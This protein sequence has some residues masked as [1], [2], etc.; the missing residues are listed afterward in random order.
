MLERRANPEVAHVTPVHYWDISPDTQTVTRGQRQTTQSG[1][2]ARAAPAGRRSGTG[3]RRGA[4][5]TRARPTLRS[6]ATG[7][8]HGN[9]K[10]VRTGRR[11]WYRRRR[12][13]RWEEQ[14]PG[15]IV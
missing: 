7:K 3:Q 15:G 13:V 5:P 2:T 12:G 11:R 1:R 9:A 4:R 6:P 10:P 14:R 8:C